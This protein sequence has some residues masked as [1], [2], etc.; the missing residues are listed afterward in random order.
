MDSDQFSPE[1]SEARLRHILDEAGL[2]QP[3]TVEH[4][5]AG[6]IT[7]IW[8]DERA[9]VIVEEVD[10]EDGG[11]DEDAGGAPTA[12]SAAHPPAERQP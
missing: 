11:D 3:D 1:A 6:G 2:R 5:K 8:W 4:L 7:C 10:D 12:A 9:V